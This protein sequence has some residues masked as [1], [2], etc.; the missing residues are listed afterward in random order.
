[1]MQRIWKAHEKA[2]W[3][4]ALS[5]MST[6]TVLLLRR[7]R[8]EL[9]RRGSLRPST[10]VAMYGAHA[11]A[12]VIS[13]HRR[14]LPLRIHPALSTAAGTTLIAGGGTACVAG[15]AT[16]ADPGQVSGTKPGELLT[17]GIY[18]YSRN[19][20]YLGYLLVLTG[21]GT[22]RRSGLALA[23]GAATGLVFRWWIPIEERHLQREFGE[24]YRQYRARVPR[25]F[26][27]PRQAGFR[28]SS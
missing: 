25:W 18:R 2:R 24:P 5:G 12:V 9:L 1:M 22:A 16:F 21:L 13:L 6:G 7:M 10:V 20:Q 27:R 26:G 11:T 28:S 8:A 4:V 14:S 19:P 17:G 15:M 23:L 3:A